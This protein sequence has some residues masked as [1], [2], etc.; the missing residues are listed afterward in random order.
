MNTEINLP[1]NGRMVEY[2][3]VPDGNAPRFKAMNS[4]T[5]IPPLKPL[6]NG[7]LNEPGL[8]HRLSKIIP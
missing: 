1:H 3:L 2:R 6:M 5:K 8:L 7:F 4:Q